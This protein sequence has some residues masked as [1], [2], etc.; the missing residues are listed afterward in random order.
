MHKSPGT[1]SEHT[2]RDLPSLSPATLP[3]CC[4]PDTQAILPNAVAT[5]LSHGLPA[6]SRPP[7]E[8]SHAPPDFWTKWSIG[9]QAG[10][11]P[12][13]ARIAG[14]PLPTNARS[15][16]V[17]AQ[18]TRSLPTPVASCRFCI[19]QAD[20]TPVSAETRLVPLVATPT[21]AEH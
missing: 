4:P 15:S 19:S 11:H 14:S 18:S 17:K 6:L 5:S 12:T 21:K 13:P 10:S 16:A 1:T 20:T 9:L 7:E 2:S 3:E 8:R